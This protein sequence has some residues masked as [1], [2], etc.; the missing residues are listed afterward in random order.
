MIKLEKRQILVDEK[1]DLIFCGEIHYF[2]LP[3]NQW[4]DRLDKLKAAG[5]NAVAS[6]VPWLC[7]ALMRFRVKPLQCRGGLLSG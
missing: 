5:C 4:R 2:R 6:C 1:P 3:R 7:H